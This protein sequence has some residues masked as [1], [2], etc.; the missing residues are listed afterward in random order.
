MAYRKGSANLADCLSRLDS[1]VD[2]VSWNEE[3]E[4]FIR[5]IAVETLAVLNDDRDDD[6]DKNTEVEIKAI[7]EATAINITEI[8]KETKSDEKLSA[9]QKAIMTHDWGNS[10][11]KPYVAF[12]NELSYINGL[13]MRG[14][15]LAVPR[16]LRS[17]MCQLAHEGHSGQSVMKNRL[18]DKYWWPNMDGET[19]KLYE[20]CEGCRLVHR[21]NPPDPMSRR[22]LPEKPWIDLA[23]DF[24]GPMPSGEY[25]LVTIDYY[26][27]YMVLEIMTK[28]TA[29][30]T[31]QRLKR[32]FRTWGYPRTITLDNGKQFVS[33]EFGNFCKTLS[34]HLNHSTPYWPQANGEVERQNRFLLKRLKISNA[35]YGNWKTELDDYLILYINSPHSVTGQAPSE[36]LQNRKLR[37]KLPQLDDLSSTPPSTEFRDR[38]TQ[39]KFEGKV[40]EDNRRGA[41]RSEIE[42]GDKVLMKNLL[43]KDKLS[44]DFHKEKFLVVDKEGTNVTIESDE[45]DKRYERYTSHLRNL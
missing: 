9:V 38:D 6:F 19:V 5:R 10:V 41:K 33:K 16:T 37:Y 18:R 3:S 31:I 15:K 30:E 32:I 1:Y 2:D 13:V 26:S 11:V 35:L 44:T 36:L 7:Q 4:V 23:I 24:L 22:S 43:P 21:A 29:Q 39:K 40:R 27:R 42:I 45:N 28:I 17:R 8:V 12:Q 25:I 20:S 14:S 34:I